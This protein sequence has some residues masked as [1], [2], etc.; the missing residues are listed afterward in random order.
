MVKGPSAGDEINR[1]RTRDPK[2]CRT[3]AGGTR[4]PSRVQ[5]L[6]GSLSE[7]QFVL[8]SQFLLFEIV[9][10]LVIG[11]WTPL[12]VGDAGFEIRVFDFERFQM[13]LSWHSQPSRLAVAKLGIRQTDIGGPTC[14]ALARFASAGPLLD[15]ANSNP[16]SE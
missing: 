10:D 15:N 2:G 5:A 1:L 12:F 13:W 16:L 3:S 4:P 6:M 11:M 7:S 8:N 9:D 14:S